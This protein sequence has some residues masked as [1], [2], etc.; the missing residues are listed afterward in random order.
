MPGGR[1]PSDPK[2]R[3]LKFVKV[4]ESGCHEWQSTLHWSGYG[5]FYYHGNQAQ[6]HRV[7]YLLFVGAIPKGKL[8]LHKCDNRKCVNPDHLYLGN[9][10]QN[11][12]DKM[13][14]FNG[15][16]GR[17]KYTTEQIKKC[18]DLYSQ[19]WTQQ[20]IADHMQIEQTSVSRFVRGK[21]LRR[22]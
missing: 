1:P 10:Q 15:L 19:G 11:T 22:D 17:M 18:I 7:A 12:A 20:K 14:R 13:N 9:H 5:K 16:W 3:F 2:Q 6:A 4:V 21:Y 8:V